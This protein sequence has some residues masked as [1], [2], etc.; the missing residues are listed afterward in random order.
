M[1]TRMNRNGMKEYYSIFH[2][3]G[4]E[5]KFFQHLNTA[6]KKNEFGTIVKAKVEIRNLLINGWG[7]HIFAVVKMY[8]KDNA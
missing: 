8:K 6:E 3:I 7:D 2:L 1:L 4:T 5:L